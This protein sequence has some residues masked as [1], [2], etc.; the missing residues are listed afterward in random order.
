MLLLSYPLHRGVPVFPGTPTL[1]VR[2]H[3]TIEADG[4]RSAMVEFNTHT[5]THMDLPAHFHGEGSDTSS[6]PAIFKLHPARCIDVTAEGD[7]PLR[8]EGLPDDLGNVEALLIRTGYHRLRE[9]DPE[10]YMHEHPWLHPEA[11]ERLIRLKNL[12]AVGLDTLSAASPSHPDKG[13]ETH[14][15]LLRP[16]RP[17]AILEDMDLSDDRL[18][19]GELTLYIVPLFTA[20]VDSTPVTVLATPMRSGKVYLFLF[21]RPYVNPLY[22]VVLV[23][24]LQPEASFR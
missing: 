14:R 9:N 11:A 10:R 4:S 24:V 20:D 17:I 19:E 16:D 18:T 6:L 13:G 8:L 7:V 5:G 12:K 3:Q 23:D 1:K 22:V 21:T 15:L 2:E